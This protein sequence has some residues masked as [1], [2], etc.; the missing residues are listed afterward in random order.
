M[1]TP[2]GKFVLEKYSSLKVERKNWESHW[3]DV[4]D[5]M[6]PR[7]ADMTKSRSQRDKRHEL[8]FDG[9]ATHALE[10]LAASLHG[11]LTNTVSPW[12]SLKYKNEELNQE[13]EAIEWLEDCTNVLNQAFNR[14][15]FQQEIFELYH[16]LIAFGTAALFIA[17]DDENE[18]RFKNIHISEI[19]ISED[20][21]GFVNNLTRKFKMKA[22]N[23][24]SAFPKAELNA[25][26]SKK[27]EKAP[28]DDVNIIHCVHPSD[29]YTNKKF[30]S[31]YVHED[32]GSVLSE[33]GFAEFP[34]A[35]PRY[36]KSSNEIYGRSPAMNALP[37][38]KM[39]NL[40]S[41]TSIKAAQK[42]I[43]PPLLVP[44]DGFMLPIRTVPGGLNYYRA[45][46]RD[47]IEP[48]QIGAA[49]PVGIQME[50]QRRDAIRQNFFVDQLLST[51]GTQMTATEVLQRNEEKMRILGPV[52]G[53]LQSELL[54]PLITRCFSILIRNNKFK[55][56]PEFLGNQNIEIEYVSP[57]AKAQK[58]GEVQSLMRGIELMGS[59]Q[60][61]A[62]VFDYLDTDNLMSYIKDVLGIPAK[63][64]KSKGQ[65]AQI[66]QQREA[67]QEQ[68]A[69][70]QQDMQE[71]EIA[72][73]AAPLAKVLNE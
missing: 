62:P 39:L 11:M 37:D 15:N 58:T 17:E 2:T 12:F 19:Y 72:N 48:L 61:V 73:K 14:S 63:I 5:Y 31:V 21:K 4:A 23:L 67:Q 28:N 51:Q 3:Q 49:N 53:R 52:L 20:E 44:D 9:T 68:Q 71:A 26:L 66:R 42:Q 7:K 45:G 8:I 55:P 34:F 50:E 69:Q 40:M 47:R 24:M 30:H 29:L 57:L 32:S 41:K 35:V 43:D 1:I 13:D 18:L 38:V 10:L 70:M 54:Q 59:L 6:L 33:N 16:D 60:N 36:L 27:I 65:V 46:T 56:A 22:A 64:L 25:E